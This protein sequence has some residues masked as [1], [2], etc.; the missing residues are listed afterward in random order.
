MIFFRMHAATDG[1]LLVQKTA[2]SVQRSEIMMKHF[3]RPNGGV[4][5]L[6]LLLLAFFSVEAFAQ[7]YR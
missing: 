4:L 5:A 2:R 6:A 1:S 7:L 3:P